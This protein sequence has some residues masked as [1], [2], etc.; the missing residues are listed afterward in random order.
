MSEVV[1]KSIDD[2]R[3]QVF[4]L[5]PAILA[6]GKTVSIQQLQETVSAVEC[7]QRIQMAEAE[8]ARFN[9]EKEKYE[10]ILAEIEK[11]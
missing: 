10:A 9:T 1:E 8:I 5:A 11:L 7:H 6:D 4:E 3:Y 2:S